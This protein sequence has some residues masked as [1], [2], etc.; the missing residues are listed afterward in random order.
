M[1]KSG[2]IK[3]LVQH[4][5]KDVGDI[6]RKIGGDL[7]V[8]T[9]REII[10]R[11]DRVD[12]SPG[13]EKGADLINLPYGVNISRQKIVNSIL[14]KQMPKSGTDADRF[15]LWV[16]GDPSDNS[17]IAYQAYVF[18]WL[19][20]KPWR[21]TRNNIRDVIQRVAKGSITYLGEKS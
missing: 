10:K 20:S 6:S 12:D 11:Y 17:T 2:D 1:I 15:G 14:P 4:M 3:K 16:P 21:M 8:E 18:E 7:Q 9:K 19:G 5:A 13:G